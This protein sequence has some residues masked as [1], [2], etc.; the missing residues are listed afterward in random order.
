MD[1]KNSNK[2]LGKENISNPN[3]G[4]SSKN[5]DF[6]NSIN[7]PSGGSSLS[8]SFSGGESSGEK[9]KGLIDKAVDVGGDMA[10]D[11][12]AASLGIPPA[13]TGPIKDSEIVEELKEVASKKVKSTLRMWII[14]AAIGLLSFVLLI[15]ALMKLVEPITAL[16]E[17]IV[18]AAITVKNVAEDFFERTK[19]LFFHGY[20]ASNEKTLFGIIQSKSNSF[21]A[22]YGRTLNIPLVSAALFYDGDEND[23]RPIEFEDGKEV[24]VGRISNEKL[25]KRIKYIDDVL[26]RMLAIKEYKYRCDYKLM[27]TDKG[28]YE[29]TLVT[30][31]FVLEEDE[32]KAGRTCNENNLTGD[33]QNDDDFIF[34]YKEV[35]DEQGF[36]Y[37]LK[38]DLMD[39]G[40]TLVEHIFKEKF[41]E[42]G[43]EDPI[44]QD[45]TLYYETWILLYGKPNIDM[46]CYF[47]GTLDREV[48]T[49]FAPPFKGHYR[50]T[51]RFGV[52]AN[53][54]GD[55]DQKYE[56]HQ[57][58]D[59]VATE[60]TNIYAVADGVVT[61]SM[62]YD[63]AGNYV[64]IRHDFGGEVYHT[65]YMHM[66]ELS[67]L[68]VG[69]SVKQGDLI[70]VM[71]STGRSTGPHLHFAVYVGSGSSRE[72]KNPENLFSEAENYTYNCVDPDEEPI[73]SCTLNGAIATYAYDDEKSFNLIRAILDEDR[74]RVLF[75][76]FN[77]EDFSR[78]YDS[79][80]TKTIVN[81]ENM[82]VDMNGQTSTFIDPFRDYKER[83]FVLDSIGEYNESVY[84]TIGIGFSQF[85][86]SLYNQYGYRSPKEMFEI[87]NNNNIEYV[88]TTF[89]HIIAT[90]PYVG[91][92]MTTIDTPEG[93]KY[94]VASGDTIDSIA[95]KLGVP[96]SDLLAD[97]ESTNNIISG[98]KIR[99]SNKAAITGVL[100]AAYSKISEDSP[101]NR[102]MN[103]PS[104]VRRVIGNYE[105]FSGNPTSTAENFINECLIVPKPDWEDCITWENNGACKKNLQ[106]HSALA[107]YYL[108]A[109]PTVA[110]KRVL[111]YGLSLWGK[112]R[113]CG[114]CNLDNAECNFI[115][116]I[117]GKIGKDA[118][119]YSY[120]GI[121]C[122]PWARSW[123]K[124]GF[125][126][127]WKELHTYSFPG[128]PYYK[129]AQDLENNVVSYK[130]GGG[131]FTAGLAGLDCDGYVNWTLNHAFQEFENNAFPV[132]S[133]VCNGETKYTFAT[134]FSNVPDFKDFATSIVPL[135]KPGD[136]ICN[137]TSAKFGTAAQTADPTW[138]YAGGSRHVMFFLGFQDANGNMT[139]DSGD[140]VYVLHSS[141]YGVR[142]DK[143]QA[144]SKD[145]LQYSSF[146][147]YK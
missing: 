98:K 6:Q 28:V 62:N 143:I 27:G 137:S 68:T 1:P 13:A 47:P 65:Q 141:L 52:R 32:S 122:S 60:D 63:R 93:S 20:F 78:L 2:K 127:K 8:D 48:M 31:K 10:I 56:I 114:A 34:V 113:Y 121:R 117:T 35:Y 95:N 39:D 14:F 12:G 5:M 100:K 72:Y 130:S 136:V 15:G 40:R 129:N 53:P 104:Y 76:N 119:K 9:K 110:G 67:H 134:Q 54:L 116:P 77:T 118:H 131:T 87:F 112:V 135:L 147:T 145:W 45:I 3:L 89:N 19:N 59:L 111:A 144:T 115:N 139:V 133:T 97:G 86:S 105:R 83:K 22:K 132:M 109:A 128:V 50:I 140:F 107:N 57:G 17:G 142:V 37:R 103:D 84:G 74:N 38:Y 64:T 91:E 36:A 29:L 23:M 42:V 124:Q 126:P 24:H 106:T 21:S 125:N 90:N 16:V 44:I 146:A 108:K 51:S 55:S 43:G 120:S 71:G 49:V 7:K 92:I 88:K 80:K 138:N 11:A 69:Q 26:D 4:K 123:G 79:S 99:I 33:S 94:T 41:D 61:T 73:G 58:I 46:E 25:N 30:E 18:G 70:G 66:K 96:S 101:V 85:P 102:F 82:T 81:F 75:I